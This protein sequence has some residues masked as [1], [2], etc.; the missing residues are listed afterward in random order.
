MYD[1]IQAYGGVKVSRSIYIIKMQN[2]II[3]QNANL[4]DIA[5]K[6]H[7]FLTKI[8]IQFI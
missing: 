2:I 8:L 1:G 7:L 4:N 6:W 5:V 3:M